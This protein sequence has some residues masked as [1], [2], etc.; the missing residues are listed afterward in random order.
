MS[1]IS[2]DESHSV[3]QFNHSSDDQCSSSFIGSII[4]ISDWIVVD[5]VLG[6]W[7]IYV[8]TAENLTIVFPLTWSQTHVHAMCRCVA[9]FVSPTTAAEIENAGLKTDNAAE[10]HM[11]PPCDQRGKYFQHR[12]EDWSSFTYS[13]NDIKIE[14]V[15]IHS[16]VVNSNSIWSRIHCQ[17]DRWFQRKS[18][19]HAVIAPENL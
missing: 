8:I 9:V 2:I 18:D 13:I 19:H 7:F 5:L 14:N 17:K 11:L 12:F 10:F 16:R 4:S 15:V 1:S 3:N 6:W